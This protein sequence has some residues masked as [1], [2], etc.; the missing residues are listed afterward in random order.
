[1]TAAIEICGPAEPW[2]YGL[3]LPLQMEGRR[4]VVAEVECLSGRIGVGCNDGGLVRWNSNCVPLCPSDGRKRVVLV[5]E[6]PEPAHLIVCNYDHSESRAVLHSFDVVDYDSLPARD[7][8][9][10]RLTQCSYWHYD[11]EFPY[12]LAVKA[13]IPTQQQFH[14]V[15]RRVL[16]R[17]M[18]ETAPN[19]RTVLDLGCSSGWHSLQMAK[20]GLSVRAIDIDPDQINQAQLVK[21]LLGEGLDLSFE[22][23]DVS[24]L[25]P[26]PYDLV[27]CSGLLYHLKDIY[28]ACRK[29]FDCATIAAVIH[30]HVDTFEGLTMRLHDHQQLPGVVYNGSYEFCFIPTLEVLVRCFRE[31]GF[32]EVRPFRAMELIEEREMVGLSDAYDDLLRHHTA[33]LALRK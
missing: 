29:I 10:A 15:S 4:A 27:H 6:Q 23:G 17:L 9:E 22:V 30:S 3:A 11:Y 13:N 16:D 28:G 20:R 7:R 12:G 26:Q 8:Y 25:Q 2:G 18:A 1:M 5:L 14:N 31:V 33:Y 21:E 32:P 19:A 24:A